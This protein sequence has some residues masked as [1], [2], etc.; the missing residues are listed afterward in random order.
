MSHLILG[1]KRV[2]VFDQVAQQNGLLAIVTLVFESLVSMR[3]RDLIAIGLN[4]LVAAC[5]RVHPL[6][7]ALFHK[8][9]AQIA[10]PSQLFGV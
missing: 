2:L 1:R 4:G 8:L 9:A 6:L 5:A 3:V 10:T 7:A